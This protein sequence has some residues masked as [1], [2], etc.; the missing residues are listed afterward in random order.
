MK[1]P[2][3]CY[4]RGS[5][6]AEGGNKVQCTQDLDIVSTLLKQRFCASLTF[7]AVLFEVFSSKE[8]D[9]FK[10]R[11]QCGAPADPF[12][13]AFVS[14]FS[15]FCFQD[16]TMHIN[17]SSEQHTQSI[18]KLLKNISTKP[19]CVNE[20]GRWGLKISSEILLVSNRLSSS[21]FLPQNNINWRQSNTFHPLSKCSRNNLSSL[22]RWKVELCP[23]KTSAWSRHPFL[24]VLTDAGPVRLS[25][26][27]PSVLWVLHFY[28]KKTLWH[29][30]IDYGCIIG[31]FAQSFINIHGNCSPLTKTELSELFGY[32]VLRSCCLMQECL[33]S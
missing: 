25:G 29:V 19:E 1:V 2:L 32:S 20:F 16:L 6:A 33:A 14:L 12:L 3:I 30:Y 11:L 10:R 8:Y 7:F 31:N 24:P 4:Y 5:S 9:H 17:A 26:T 22:C 15:A 13:S 23:W 27:P 18:G 21:C 28:T